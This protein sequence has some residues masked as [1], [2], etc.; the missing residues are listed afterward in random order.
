MS[1]SGKKKLKKHLPSEAHETRSRPVLPTPPGTAPGVTEIPEDAEETRINALVYNG[2]RFFESPIETVAEL[3]A[4][5]EGDDIVWL[6]IEGYGSQDKL[7][8]LQHLFKLHNL[9][10][11]DMLNG[12]QRPKLEP[13]EDNIFIVARVPQGGGGRTR[14]LNILIGEKYVLT[15]FEKE[16]EWLEPVRQRIRDRIGRIRDRGADYLVYAILDTVVDSY[17]PV[18]EQYGERLERLEIEIL[19]KPAQNTVH[20][21]HA[22]KRSLLRLRRSIWPHREVVNTL[23]RD[24]DMITQETTVYLRDCY[25]HLIRVAELLE[26]M[27][28]VCS[29]LMSTYLS[30]LSNRM[31]E[32][33]KV[34]TIIATI[35]IPLSFVAGVYGM[36][37]DAAASPWN[38]PELRWVFGYP[39]VVGLMALIAGGMLF[40]FWRR[41]W[42]D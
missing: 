31:N 16:D 10:L 27:R 38:M 20:R 2:D 21:I 39:T 30:S 4:L 18:V 17:Y 32:V 23:L 24:T 19:R 13:Y 40:F 34:L 26:T 35:F 29:D 3:E 11:E 25:D 28:E 15:C 9:A 7:D 41:G 12:Q 6:T 37:F 1:P 5:L 8:A 22:I 36:N 42:F 14:Q 33:M